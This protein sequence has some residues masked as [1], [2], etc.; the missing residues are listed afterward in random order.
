MNTNNYKLIQSRVIEAVNQ[1]FEQNGKKEIPDVKMVSLTAQTDNRTA[2]KFMYEWW[3]SYKAADKEKLLHHT[4]DLSKV[5]DDRLK[6]VSLDVE[7]LMKEINLYADSLNY[8]PDA[9]IPLGNYIGDALQ[10]INHKILLVYADSLD[11]QKDRHKLQEKVQDLQTQAINLT[12]DLYNARTGY[13][14][15]I[16]DLREQLDE[17]RR[18]LAVARLLI[19]S[20]KQ[21]K[22]ANNKKNLFYYN[23]FYPF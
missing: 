20:L 9:D 8:L 4:P 11:K 15:K 16:I 19:K 3:D 14:K 17:K 7:C 22:R 12:A 2:L 13:A 1:L 10:A 18:E 21:E 5:Q 23:N 6:K